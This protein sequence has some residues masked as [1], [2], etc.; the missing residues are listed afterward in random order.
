L[1]EEII[2]LTLT[3]EAVSIVPHGISVAL[4]MSLTRKEMQGASAADNRVCDIAQD[5]AAAQNH[6]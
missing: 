3:M 4:P 5:L 2:A 1:P 6:A